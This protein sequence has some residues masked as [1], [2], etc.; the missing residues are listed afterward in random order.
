MF[1]NHFFNWTAQLKGSGHEI[2]WLDVFD[3]NTK[4]KELDFVFQIVGWR[5]KIKYP[6]RYW[7]KKHLPNLN[8][9]INI[10]NQCDFSKLFERNLLEINPDV[11]HSFVMYSASVPILK[12]MKRNPEIKWIYSAWGNDLYFYQNES[13]KLQGIKETLPRIDYM[14]A[15]CSRDHDIAKKHGF[16]GK[17]LGTFPTGGGYDFESYKTYVLPFPTRKKIIIKGY[18]HNFGRCINVLEAIILL[19]DEL[20]NHDILVFA[21][22]KKVFEYAKAK[23]LDTWENITICGSLSHNIVLKHMGESQI[24]IG[25][26]ISDGMPN[27]L[28]E[29][30]IMGAFPIQS[31]PGGAT[32]ELIEHGKNGL[33]IQDPEDVMK[34]ANL[35]LKS[36]GNLRLIQEGIMYNNQF[37]KPRL[38]REK[39]KSQV[40]R[41]YKLI[42]EELKKY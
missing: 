42:E 10:F 17:Y 24:Y 27:T 40:L 36:I 29:A 30:I 8:R 32:E 26:S 23:N 22:N 9:I 11:V 6:G 35:I 21:A 18:E 39:V 14:F 4:V 38:E 13:L 25:N 2:Y 31:N 16:S 3:S 41:K 19:K 34:I 1:S 12:V 15:D 37:I 7:I 20:K 33:L 28:L 5:N